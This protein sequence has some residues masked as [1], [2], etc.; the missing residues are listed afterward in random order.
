MSK[1]RFGQSEISIPGFRSRPSVIG[2]LIGKDFSPAVFD[3]P[4]MRDANLAYYVGDKRTIIDVVPALG[5]V[6]QHLPNGKILFFHCIKDSLTKD[7]ICNFFNEVCVDV[8]FKLKPNGIATIQTR[9][10]LLSTYTPYAKDTGINKITLTLSSPDLELFFDNYYGYDIE[11]Q[12][13]FMFQAKQGREI[14]P[15]QASKM[16]TDECIE[17]DG[18]GSYFY[19]YVKN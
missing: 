3:D 18:V 5:K 9:K 16:T 11:W 4:E 1:K 6:L 14:T 8:P 10:T 17:Y 2:K 7:D 19:E 12:G 13:G 15:E